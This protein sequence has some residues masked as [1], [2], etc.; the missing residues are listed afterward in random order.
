M[1]FDPNTSVW[2]KDN[3]WFAVHYFNND[4]E[5]LLTSKII[6]SESTFLTESICQKK[7]N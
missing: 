2:N 5:K 6:G 7:K 3:A 4:E 1:Y